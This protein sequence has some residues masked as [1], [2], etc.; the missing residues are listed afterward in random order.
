MTEH[1]RSY[2]ERYQ[3][4]SKDLKRAHELKEACN[5]WFEIAKANRENNLLDTKERLY[6]FYDVVKASG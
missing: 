1:Q 4:L 3:R 5:V 2:L 6:Q